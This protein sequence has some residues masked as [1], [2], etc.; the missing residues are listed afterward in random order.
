MKKLNIAEAS[1][2]IGGC[3]QT[4]SDSFEWT[5]SGNDDVCKAVT[6]CTDKNGVV[7]KTYRTAPY[8]SCKVPG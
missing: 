8:S 5:T 4:C 6:T 1:I 7:T 2:V 3:C